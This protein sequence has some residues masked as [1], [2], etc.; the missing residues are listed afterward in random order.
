MPKKIFK[1]VERKYIINYRLF[2]YKYGKGENGK[3][4]AV[5]RERYNVEN[6]FSEIPGAG[7]FWHFPPTIH[8]VDWYDKGILFSLF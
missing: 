8:G 1:I 7:D 6:N 2:V 5:S 4:D 3:A